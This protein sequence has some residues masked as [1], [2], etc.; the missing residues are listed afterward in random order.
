M[1]LSY[2]QALQQDAKLNLAS[3]IEQAGILQT[4]AKETR[5]RQADPL[6]AKQSKAAFAPPISDELA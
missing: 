4:I 3:I 6:A 2:F 5:L 1:V